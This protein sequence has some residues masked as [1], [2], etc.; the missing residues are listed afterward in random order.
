MKDGPSIAPV[1]YSSRGVA[2]LP[3][4]RAPVAAEDAV[5]S[6]RRMIEAENEMRMRMAKAAED[7]RMKVPFPLLIKPKKNEKPPPLDLNE[8]IRNLISFSAS[9]ILLSLSA[10]SSTGALSSGRGATPP[11]EAYAT[12]AIDGTS[13]T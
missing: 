10:A 4:D 11:R 5:E 1:S 6:E 7:E 9:I 8:A 13:F 12:G 2:P 3:D